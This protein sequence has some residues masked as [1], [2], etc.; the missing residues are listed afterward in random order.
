MAMKFKCKDCRHS[1]ELKNG[2]EE[3][4]P[5]C[6]SDNIQPA[7]TAMSI[8][9]KFSLFLGMAAV[10]YFVTTLVLDTQ[11]EKKIPGG[12]IAE[13]KELPHKT[14]LL[15]NV[16]A[17]AENT[18][19]ITSVEP[20]EPIDSAEFTVSA[21]ILNQNNFSFA[22]QCMRIPADYQVEEYRLFLKESD[23]EPVITAKSDGK[24]SSDKYIAKDGRYYIQ[25][26]FNNNNTTTR[27]P[28]EGVVK[29]ASPAEVVKPKKMEMNEL[30]TLIDGSLAAGFNNKNGKE[31][32]DT[33]LK[34]K[35]RDKRVN[36]NA[37]IVLH[38]K[39]DDSG[40]A[41][42]EKKLTGASSLIKEAKMKH[43]KKLTVLSVQ[44][45]DATNV[46]DSF[47]VEVLK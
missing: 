36:S 35:S 11:D 4:C 44:Y 38:I 7:G 8:I 18:D 43:Y 21:L 32:P 42:E 15:D 30:Q 39:S 16:V 9:G 17:D 41:P 10:G 33:W 12:Q 29:P 1:F 34:P 47:E 19:T 23:T 5:N 45:N 20:L 24:F 40:N 3:V 28:I 22:V 27:K 14:G 2:D 46:I 25:A 37:K 13:E 31:D 6:K 26:V